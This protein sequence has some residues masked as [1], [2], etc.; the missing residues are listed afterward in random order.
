MRLFTGEA[1]PLGLLIVVAFLVAENRLSGAWTSVLVGPGPRGT[2]SG[3]VAQG[4][5]CSAARG[6][7]ADHG[8]SCSAARGVFP[9]QRSNSCL[10]HWQADSLPLSHQGGPLPLP[11]HWK[12]QAPL[13]VKGASFRAPGEAFH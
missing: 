9:D 3:A 13:S 10:L 8:L 12:K 11:F 1:A 2:G 6:V 7:F 4:L 5:S